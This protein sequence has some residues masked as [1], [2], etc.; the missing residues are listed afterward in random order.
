MIN[1][2]SAN[3]TKWSNILKQFVVQTH[4][5]HTQI[6]NLRFCLLSNCF[7]GM[8][9]K[10]KTCSFISSRG[11]YRRLSTSQISDMPRA[12]FEALQN[13]NSGFTEWSCA[14]VISTISRP[15]YQFLHTFRYNKIHLLSINLG[16]FNKEFKLLIAQFKRFETFSNSTLFA[17]SS[18]VND[19]G[20]RIKNKAN[21]AK[22]PLDIMNYM[23]QRNCV[24][25]LN[26]Q[27]NL[28]ILIT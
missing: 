28:N 10:Q 20:W 13:L 27:Q 12:G 21:K 9:D 11:H 7:C 18:C 16:Q 14:V 1:P 24:T 4:S 25:K 22:T 8:F 3:P 5:M 26:K 17:Q 19:K 6:Q 2:L 23:K 15:H